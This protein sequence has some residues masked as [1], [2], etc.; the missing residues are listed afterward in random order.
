MFS[1]IS[2]P[3]PS[4]QM[5]MLRMVMLPR[6]YRSEHNAIVAILD[7]AAD[8]GPALSTVFPARG[9]VRRPQ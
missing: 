1:E 9:R 6:Y 3:V 5:M 4:Q 2:L 7:D 8:D